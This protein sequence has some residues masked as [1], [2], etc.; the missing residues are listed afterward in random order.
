MRPLSPCGDCLH[1]CSKEFPPD[2]ISALESS[3]SFGCHMIFCSAHKSEYRGTNPS[4][5]HNSPFSVNMFN[6]LL[7]TPYVPLQPYNRHFVEPSIRLP[8]SLRLTRTGV[9]QQFPLK[10]IVGV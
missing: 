7:E 2:G 4:G 1:S 3:F 10:Y 8:V 5:A 9:A 6:S